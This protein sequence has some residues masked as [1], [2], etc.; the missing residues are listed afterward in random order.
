MAFMKF[1]F[2]YILK[3]N[4]K[5]LFKQYFGWSFYVSLASNLFLFIA[6]IIGCSATSAVLAGGSNRLVKIEVSILL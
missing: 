5:I 1:V 3:S 4:I 6:S 2:Y